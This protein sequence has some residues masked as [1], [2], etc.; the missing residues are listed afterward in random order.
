MSVYQFI[1]V[2]TATSQECLYE[3]YLYISLYNKCLY[4]I[5]YNI[6]FFVYVYESAYEV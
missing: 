2:I 6:I 4:L 5:L 3:Y 1:L